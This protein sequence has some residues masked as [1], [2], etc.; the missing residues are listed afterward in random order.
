MKNQTAAATR[1]SSSC[2]HGHSHRHGAPP[3]PSDCLEVPTAFGSSETILTWPIF[4]GRWSRNFLSQ[5]ILIGSLSSGSDAQGD[6]HHYHH[7]RNPSKGRVKRA[8]QGINE[9]NVPGLVDC[10]LQLVHSKNPVLNTRQ[11][12]EAARHVA[13]DGVGW[14]ASS[15]IVVRSSTLIVNTLAIHSI[16][17][18]TLSVCG[19]RRQLAIHS[20]AHSCIAYDYSID[21]HRYSCSPAPWA[22]LHVH[23]IHHPRW[24][25][26]AGALL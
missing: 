20:T 4:N 11:I 19:L 13:E 3:S 9:E 21:A 23:S 2:G 25:C 18:L 15:C 7:H 17:D 16:Q 26:S 6:H 22:P 10:F 12:R 14:D 5:E 8:S 1:T 24:A